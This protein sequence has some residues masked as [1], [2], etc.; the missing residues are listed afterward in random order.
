MNIFELTKFV[1]VIQ[2]PI[3]KTFDLKISII[4]MEVLQDSNKDMII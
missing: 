1:F 2:V 3:E 4:D